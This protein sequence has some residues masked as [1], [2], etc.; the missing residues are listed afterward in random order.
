MGA[1]TSGR[2]ARTG[3]FALLLALTLLLLAGSAQAAPIGVNTTADE[4][5]TDGDCSL[6]EAVEA[7]NTNAVVDACAAGEAGP[8][9]VDEIS[10]SVTGTITLG[11]TLPTI[12]DDL[13]I[14]GPAAPGIT[15]SG[16]DSVRVLVVGTG[17]TLELKELT[18]ADGRAGFDGGGIVNAGTLTVTDSTISGNSAGIGAG[19]GILNFGTLTVTNSTFSGNDGDSGGG[20]YNRGILTATNST[21]SG[22][23]A[24]TLGGGIENF[25]GTAT[26]R[27]TIVANSPSG[28]NC[29]GTIT[30]GGGNLSWPDTSCPGINEDPLLDPAGLQD[31][32]GPTKT[33]ALDPESPAIDAALAANCPATDQRGV[34]RPQGEGCDIG[35]F[36]L[37]VLSLTV[38]PASD[39]NTAG[40]TDCVGVHVRDAFFD[41]VPGVTVVLTTRGANSRGPKSKV[42]GPFGGAILCYTGTRAGT[43]TITVF[44]DLNSNGVDD[45]AGEANASATNTYTAADPRFLSLSP[46]ESTSTVG[47]TQCGPSH[48][49]ALTAIVRDRFDNRTPGESVIFTV[50][51]DHSRGPATMTT[52]A[53]GRAIYCY[54]VISKTGTDTIRAFADTDTDTLRDPGEPGDFAIKTWVGP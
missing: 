26:L 28:G 43:D 29:A 45:G 16:N 50:S 36:E 48:A 3:V 49:Q 38:S 2:I 13:T 14:D 44:A 6:R 4:L 30:D 23:S 37:Q 5:N 8:T 33:I 39:T 11:S 20:I 41:P 53:R 51:G 1:T 22:N 42:T 15:I 54:L 7:A 34:G 9:V 40:E 52:D 35:A 17:E 10:F 19:G 25:D 24:S 32:G 18:V 12:A 21:F 47:D 27:N 46:S 31:N